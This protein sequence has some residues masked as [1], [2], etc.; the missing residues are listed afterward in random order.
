MR[1]PILLSMLR[2]HAPEVQEKSE[3]LVSPTQFTS[4]PSDGGLLPV[5]DNVIDL[6]LVEG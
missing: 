3:C 2:I 6:F 1:S 4:H 5:H